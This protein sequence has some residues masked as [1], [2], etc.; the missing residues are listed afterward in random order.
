MRKYFELCV[1][2]QDLPR[3]LGQHSGG[4]VICQGQLDSVV[5]LEP[6]TMPGRVVVQW[7][8]ED[9]ADMGIIK[10]DLLGLGMMAVLEESINLIRDHYGEEVDLAQLPADDPTVYSTLQKADTIG[11]FQ[12]ESRA[13]MSCLPRLRP[14]RF[15]DIVVQVAIIRPGP[16]V[17]QMV[18]PYL[19]RRQ[20]REA[21]DLSASF[22]G[23]G[24]GAHSGR[25]AFSGTT[26][27]HGDGGGGIH[28]RRG[29]RAAPGDGFQAIG[30]TH[31]GN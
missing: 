25:A 20:G 27:A 31:E 17:G 30:K 9:C 28:R 5:P 6:A 2:V 21:S 15:Y 23:A 16:I 18:N 8:K 24:A 26:A 14:K 12:V 10:V 4:M 3:H 29:G 19:K 13:Q 7:D 22:A 1:A 11:M